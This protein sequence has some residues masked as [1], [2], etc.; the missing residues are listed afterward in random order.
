MSRLNYME[1]VEKWAVFEVSAKGKTD[2]NPFVDYRIQGTF[3][4]R[5]ETRQVDGFYDGDGVYTV[6]FMPSF[7]GRYT[8]EIGGN[9]SP[10]TATGSFEVTAPTGNNHGP[11]RV[12]NTFHFAYED[13]TPYYP[14]G[15]TCYVWTHQSQVL[16]EQTLEALKNSGF[17]KIRFCVFPKHYDFNLHDPITFPYE[18]TPVDNSVIHRENFSKFGG[19]AP[20]NDWDFHRFNPL[21]FQLFEKRIQDLMDLG[22]EADLIVMHPYDRWGFSE[23]DAECDDLYWH[24]VV[25]RFSAYRN[26]WWSLANEYDLMRKKTL[27]DW[28]RYAAILCSKD[29]YGRLRSIHNCMPFYDY[30]R[31]WITHCC[32]Q[33]QDAYKCAE[34]VGVYRGQFGKPIVLDEIAYEGN[35]QHGWGN[36]SGKELTRR[37]W[38]ATCRGGY[39]GHGETYM[40]PD[41]ILWWSHG[42]TLHGDSPD[43]LKFLAGI[44]QESPGIGLTPVPCRW[45]EVAASADAVFT[46][47]SSVHDYYLYYYGFNRPSFRTFHFDDRTLYEVELI[48][49]WEMTIEKKGT[50]KGLFRVDMPGKEYMAVR[51]RKSGHQE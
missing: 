48:D 2:G 4:H 14:V 38:E 51:M 9:F 19:S 47:F 25:A 13:A 36:I 29:P 20:G 35:V 39:A 22:I 50:F 12:A 31:P 26:V 16:Q 40:H 30:T 45:D 21:H 24:Y 15:T 49:T 17:N 23:M 41:D 44:L 6:R 46:S 18:G 10:D 37:F 43:R 11:V 42:G 7:E 8:F 28:E 27:A 34:L 33:R 3:T 1:S 32:I 5:N